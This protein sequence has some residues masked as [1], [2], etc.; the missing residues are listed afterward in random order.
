MPVLQSHLKLGFETQGR[1]GLESYLKFGF[2][3]QRPQRPQ[4]TIRMKRKG[5]E[6]IRRDRRDGK[7]RDLERKF[8]SSLLT[9]AAPVYFFP[10]FII[11]L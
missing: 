11:P 10:L 6:V 3:T 1:K 4:R 9:L 8:L 5:E 2:E 7:R